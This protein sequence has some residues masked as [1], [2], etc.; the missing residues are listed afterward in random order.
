MPQC[1]QAPPDELRERALSMLDEI[2]K[3]QEVTRLHRVYYMQLARKY[4]CTYDAIGGA[5]GISP[6]GARKF[7]E[8]AAE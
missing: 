5:L 2:R 7:L 1:I 3:R 8:R 4:G 6:E